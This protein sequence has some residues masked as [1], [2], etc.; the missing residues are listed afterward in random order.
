MK[1]EKIL[2]LCAFLCVVFMPN[3]SFGNDNYCLF[4][5]SNICQKKD[6]SLVRGWIGCFF[7]DGIE[8]EEH[9]LSCVGY[10]KYYDPDEKLCKPCPSPVGSLS[11]APFYEKSASVTT[12]EESCRI[13]T[14]NPD[15][16]CVTVYKYSSGADMYII[17]RSVD[18]IRAPENRYVLRNGNSVSCPL[19]RDAFPDKPYSSGGNIDQSGCF[20]CGAGSC[21][22]GDYCYE[23]SAGYKCPGDGG[24]SRNGAAQNCDT[25]FLGSGIYGIAKCGINQYSEAG[26]S[27]CLDCASGYTTY[28]SPLCS[29]D[30]GTCTSADACVL[31]TPRF[32]FNS[33][34]NCDSGASFVWPDSVIQG[35]VDQTKIKKRQHRPLAL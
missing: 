32:C 7:Q 1:F 34:V 30:G 8:D 21:I 33:L 16:N 3:I 10:K 35:N 22:S 9:C 20:S 23:C 19:C 18:D 28:N 29:T 27:E 5:G 4:E 24:N 2:F 11:G 26:Y 25:N 15:T 14:I 12:G 17:D 6:N 31:R 13:K